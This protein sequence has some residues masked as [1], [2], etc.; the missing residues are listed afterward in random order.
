MQMKFAALLTVTSAKLWQYNFSDLGTIPKAR[1][2][3][4]EKYIKIDDDD[5]YLVRPDLDDN[6]FY[7]IPVQDFLQVGDDYNWLEKLGVSSEVYR[8]S[9]DQK[10]SLATLTSSTSPHRAV[11]NSTSAITAPTMFISDTTPRTRAHHAASDSQATQ[12]ARERLSTPSVEAET[13]ESLPIPPPAVVEDES[14]NT[15]VMASVSQLPYIPGYRVVAR[16][17]FD[18]VHYLCIRDWSNSHVLRL[19]RPEEYLRRQPYHPIPSVLRVHTRLPIILLGE[20]FHDVYYDPS[21]LK[22][23][24]RRFHPIHKSADMRTWLVVAKPARVVGGF[25]EFIPSVAG[26]LRDGSLFASEVLLMGR[27]GS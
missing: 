27:E 5:F 22:Q 17:S 6:Q 23:A 26:V 14:S 1:G 13:P 4:L 11:S 18:G 9:L 20:R 3:T 16:W 24:T 7:L 2:I 25:Y 19:V 15:G 21:K 8:D 12:A 10:P